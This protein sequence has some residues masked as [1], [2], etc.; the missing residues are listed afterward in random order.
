[1]PR[2]SG[3]VGRGFTLVAVALHERARS[4]KNAGLVAATMTT[5]K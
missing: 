5:S 2:S 3:K 1:L 4:W